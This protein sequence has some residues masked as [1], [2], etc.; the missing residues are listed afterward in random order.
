MSGRLG[1]C[2]LVGGLRCDR[3]YYHFVERDVF[4]I[5]LCVLHFREEL[6]V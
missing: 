4:V 2:R 6:K 5:P 1:C 3:R